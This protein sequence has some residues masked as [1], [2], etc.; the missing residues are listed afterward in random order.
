MIGTD[1]IFPVRD[2]LSKRYGCFSDGFAS[3]QIGFDVAGGSHRLGTGKTGLYTP[4]IHT[5]TSFTPTVSTAGNSR[6]GKGAMEPHNP[7]VKSAS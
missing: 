6:G 5:T 1:D 3:L 2:V 4:Y 7:G